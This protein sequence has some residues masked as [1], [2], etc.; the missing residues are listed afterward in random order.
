MVRF[1]NNDGDYKGLMELAV[2]EERERCAKVVDSFD[3][4]Q[5]S[6]TQRNVIRIAAHAIREGD[7]K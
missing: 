3:T 4:A 1:R 7:S 5:W 6:D 2:K